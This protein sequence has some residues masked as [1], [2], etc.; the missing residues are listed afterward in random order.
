MGKARDFKFGPGQVIRL[1]F[2]TPCNISATATARVFKFRFLDG[3][4]KY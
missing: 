4:V 2:Y 1:K 3:R